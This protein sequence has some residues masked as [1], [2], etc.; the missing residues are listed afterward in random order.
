MDLVSVTLEFVNVRI[1][2]TKKKRSVP[3]SFETENS[4][5]LYVKPCLLTD[6]HQLP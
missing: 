2:A 5:L 1:H 4:R 3:S 6:I